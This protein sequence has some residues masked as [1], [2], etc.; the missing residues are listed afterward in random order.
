MEHGK[1][2]WEDCG[3]S[4]SASKQD[5]MWYNFCE[6]G[7]DLSGFIQTLSLYVFLSS[8]TNIYFETLDL[9]SR[10][11]SVSQ[12]LCLSVCLSVRPS[13]RPSVHPSVRFYKAVAVFWKPSAI[14]PCFC[15]DL[16]L[17]F[18]LSWLLVLL[19]STFFLDIPFFCLLWYPFHN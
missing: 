15:T 9:V 2:G 11:Q 8:Y 13:F 7:D 14:P 10:S 6:R 17:N 18:L 4:T 12:L 3:R 16:V 19:P 1:I 5:R